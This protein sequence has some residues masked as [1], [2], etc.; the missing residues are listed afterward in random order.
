[1]RPESTTLAVLIYLTVNALILAVLL[2]VVRARRYENGDSRIPRTV[3]ML[4]L[5]YFWVFFLLLDYVRIGRSRLSD[6]YFMFAFAL[7]VAALVVRVA[8]LWVF[9]R[10]LAEKVG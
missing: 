9:K 6:P 4:A 2:A 5:G 8:H 3:H 7:L 1:V 10:G